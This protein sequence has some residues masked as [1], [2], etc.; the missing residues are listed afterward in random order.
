MLRIVSTSTAD[1]AKLHKFPII[2]ALDWFSISAAGSHVES[3]LLGR[4]SNVPGAHLGENISY[5]PR[6][7]GSDWVTCA[8]VGGISVHLC[9]GH[10]VSR[11]EPIVGVHSR[12]V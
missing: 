11:N 2:I 1:R 6:H 4:L 12:N 5:L 9:Q 3:V 8:K 10:H 7:R